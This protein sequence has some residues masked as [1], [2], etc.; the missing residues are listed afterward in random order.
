MSQFSQEWETFHSN[1][2]GLRS[3]WG[4][5]RREHRHP[6]EI[7]ACHPMSDLSH[8][9]PEAH[10]AGRCPFWH[11]RPAHQSLFLRHPI[12]SSEALCHSNCRRCKCC[13]SS[14][15]LEAGNSSSTR[16]EGG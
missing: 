5:G 16:L 14:H 1:S 10:R 2:Q 6:V 7:F 11:K 12:P 3:A 4:R 15:W 9:L 8:T 13:W